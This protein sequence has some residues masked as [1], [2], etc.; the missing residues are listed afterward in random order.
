MRT[1]EE[2]KKKYCIKSGITIR[3]FDKHF[4]VLHCGCNTDTCSGFI[5]VNNDK[6]SIKRHKKLY[7]VKD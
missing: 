1:R 3:Y 4:V 7:G 5:V 6:E 2:F